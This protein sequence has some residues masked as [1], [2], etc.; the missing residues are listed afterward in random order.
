MTTRKI[1]REED[2][3]PLPVPPHLNISAEMHLLTLRKN[4]TQTTPSPGC[5]QNLLLCLWGQSRSESYQKE[6][7]RKPISSCTPPSPPPVASPRWPHPYLMWFSESLTLLGD[8]GLQQDSSGWQSS[9]PL[10]ITAKWMKMT[11]FILL[12]LAA[13][14]VCA[15][16]HSLR[17][18]RTGVSSPGSGLPAYSS[19]GYVDD[20]QITN[21]N[22]DTR[23]NL[24]K[25]EWMKKMKSEYW[26]RETKYYQKAELACKDNLESLTKRFTKTGGLHIY[27]EIVGCELGDDGSTAVYN[28][29]AYNGRDFLYLDTQTWN[30][31]PVT[32]EAK[33]S[34]QAWNL[35]E[36]RQAEEW[37]NYLMN[38]CTGQLKEV[39]VCGRE[40]LEKRVHPEVKVW[41]RRQSNG[42]MRLQCLVYGFHPRAVHVKWVRNGVDDVPSD[43]M[44]PILPHPDGTYQI[45]VR[46]DVTTR[47][48]DT[49]SCHV[50][51]SSL[52][53]TVAVIWASGNTSSSVVVRVTSRVE[54]S[55]DS[56]P[57]SYL[58]RRSHLPGVRARSLTPG[59]Y[60]L[61]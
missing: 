50:V 58:N 51:H 33:F 4:S 2:H 38:T 19:I 27:Q 10:N 36:T 42:V 14:D 11:P 34:T 48:G 28:K 35:A 47:E 13:S 15:D 52:Q 6:F 49:Y 8:P 3:P 9:L 39:F 5:D 43:E 57:F 23:Q 1:Y 55:P 45:R 18:Y 44:S 60:L 40:D 41:G 12:I 22:S 26:E 46:V 31:I 25:T 17:Y 16:R 32:P 54:T 61:R 20:Q 37:R 53:E 7:T 21:Y 56:N 59:K 30:W 29:H 24:P